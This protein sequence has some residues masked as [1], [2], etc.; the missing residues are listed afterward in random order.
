MKQ[1]DDIWDENEVPE[2]DL[3]FGADDGDERPEPEY[4]T[5]YKQRVRSEDMFLGI[6]GKD[7]G[8]HCCEDLIVT[9]PSPTH[10]VSH[11][12]ACNSPDKHCTGVC[13][14]RRLTSVATGDAA[15]CESYG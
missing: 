15:G 4:K 14:S 2:E 6:D 7:P 13:L 3:A 9:V 10:M 8:S 11:H 1:S 5:A 12:S